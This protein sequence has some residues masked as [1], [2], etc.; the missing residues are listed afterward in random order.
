MLANPKFVPKI[1]SPLLTSTNHKELNNR[2]LKLF[3]LRN[4]SAVLLLCFNSFSQTVYN[5]FSRSSLEWPYKTASEHQHKFR[6]SPST[7]YFI[8]ERA[9]FKIRKL[10]QAA[11]GS[12]EEAEK[13]FSGFFF[14]EKITRKVFLRNNLY[15]SGETRTSFTAL[16]AFGKPRHF[17]GHQL[18]TAS[19]CI[20]GLN[21][22]VTKP[23]KIKTERCLSR[24]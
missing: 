11:L 7:R 6:V 15:C 9:I 2:A 1:S 10:A 13:H 8:I 17:C 21:N 16:A 19:G 24:R 14:G 20:E 3:C 5:F 23:K 22:R 12:V 4:I 18:S